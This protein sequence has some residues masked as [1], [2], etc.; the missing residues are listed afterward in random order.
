M[1]P[2]KALQFVFVLLVSALSF[3][4]KASPATI[5]SVEEYR[6]GTVKAP[7]VYLDFWASWCGP[8]KQAFP[9]MNQL[10]QQYADQGFTVIA[11]NLDSQRKDAERFLKQVPAEFP[12]VWDPK[13]EL[14]REFAVPSMPTSYLL[15][16]DGTVLHRHEGFRNSDREAIKAS[17]E[18][19]LAALP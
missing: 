2:Q 19:A 12:I 1:N 17:V 4:T 16:A 14:A 13:G 18:K 8:C 10:Q 11:I 9:F 7:L 3:T 6:A 5:I 15:S